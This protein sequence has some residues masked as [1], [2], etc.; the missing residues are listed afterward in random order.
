[1]VSE[2]PGR[3]MR[4]RRCN[5]EKDDFGGRD[6]RLLS[7][8]LEDVADWLRRQFPP[9]AYYVKTRPNLR[10]FYYKVYNSKKTLFSAQIFIIMPVFQNGFGWI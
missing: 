8:A 9:T 3:N 2:S 7:K 1:M 5:L 4:E 6:T 10:L